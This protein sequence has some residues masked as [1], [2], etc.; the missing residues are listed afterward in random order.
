MAKQSRSAGTRKGSRVPSTDRLGPT[1]VKKRR[2]RIAPDF[3]ELCLRS[4]H[5]EYVTGTTAGGEQAILFPGVP[6][7]R[8]YWFD[9]KGKYLR[10]ESRERRRPS[11]QRHLEWPE[12]RLAELRAWVEELGLT[13]GLIEVQY[14]TVSEPPRL[15]IGDYPMGWDGAEWGEGGSL[16]EMVE[17]WRGLGCFV[18]V[19]GRA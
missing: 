15:S 9:R 16:E 6:E 2:Y 18:L 7:M 12:D 19:V 4:P 3:G 17:W 10:K 8:A 5:A 14:F 13:P 11:E 1:A